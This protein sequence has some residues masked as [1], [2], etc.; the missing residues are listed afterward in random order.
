MHDGDRVA[1]AANDGEVVRDEEIGE[2]ELALEVFEQVENLR[3]DRDVERRYGFVAD[4][5][6]RTEG[7]RTG[8]PDPLPLPAG[9]SCG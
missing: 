8:N 2:A 5:E 9:N 3:L 1:H 7:E 6:L 4:N